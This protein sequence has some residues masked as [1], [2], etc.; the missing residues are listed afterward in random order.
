[1]GAFIPNFMLCTRQVSGASNPRLGRDEGCSGPRRAAGKASGD[2][3]DGGHVVVVNVPHLQCW[4]SGGCVMMWWCVA[5]GGRVNAGNV[6][7][8]REAGERGAA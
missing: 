2:G 5:L 4:I 1:M 7:Q 3:E 6:A 8:W